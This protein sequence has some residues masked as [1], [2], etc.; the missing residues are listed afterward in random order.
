MAS[1]AYW[2]DTGTPAAFLQ[3]NADL[4]DGTRPGPPAPGARQVSLGV[5]TLGAPL[6]RGEVHG[7]SLL[8]AGAQIAHDATVTGSVIGARAVVERGA[9][10]ENSVL[11]PG[12]RVGVGARVVGSILGHDC[13]VGAGCELSP[14]TVVGDD[15]EVPEGT[16]L[17]RRPGA[18]GD[19]VVTSSMPGFPGDG[20]SS[21]S[22]IPR[23]PT[24]R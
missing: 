2:L 15:F 19:G 24:C 8:G 17:V 3:A 11:L 23:G 5:W 9:H 7:P 16:R 4:L 12:A 20:V 13:V 1:D 22:L 10:V 6:V 21:P 14:V 18:G